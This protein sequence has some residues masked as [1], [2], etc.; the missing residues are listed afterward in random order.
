MREEIAELDSTASERQKV[1]FVPHSLRDQARLSIHYKFD[2]VCQATKKEEMQRE[3]S[4]GG[5]TPSVFANQSNG[6]SETVSSP[7]PQDVLLGRG[8][9]FT[10]HTGNNRF[11]EIIN[12]HVAQYFA[13]TSRNDRSRIVQQVFEQVKSRGS[14]FL[15]QNEQTGQY[16]PVCDKVAREKIGQAIRYK[17]ARRN[18]F[19]S[20]V[21]RDRSGTD[22]SRPARPLKSTSA[23][24]EQSES[25]VK[26]SFVVIELFDDQ[27]LGSA[28]GQPGEYNWPSDPSELP[29]GFEDLS[30]E[31][32]GNQT[33]FCRC[34]C[35][36]FRG[37]TCHGGSNRVNKLTSLGQASH[38]KPFG[39]TL[40]NIPKDFVCSPKQA[41]VFLPDFPFCNR[42]FKIPGRNVLE[43]FGSECPPP[44]RRAH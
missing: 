22:T 18:A 2:K 16:H 31:E 21:Q 39:T 30:E 40:M 41:P 38:P 14:R 12:E 10:W 32:F 17:K 23:P 8:F 37:G 43:P 19:R 6:S 36:A 33:R 7:R 28:L 15:R 13:A 26:R 1:S 25:T 27:T 9:S 11:Q 5:S 4:A 3:N 35:A 42:P 44:S 24:L 29:Q 34:K 20:S